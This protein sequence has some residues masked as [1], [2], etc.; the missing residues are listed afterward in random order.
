MN[1]DE[2]KRKLGLRIKYFRT[3]RKMTQAQLA[4][5]IKMEEK[6]ISKIE[7]GH[8]NINLETLYKFSQALNVD[9]SK[10]FIFED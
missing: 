2:Y 8:Q 4:D 3:V 10:L 1:F 7:N 6:Y 9:T 5:I